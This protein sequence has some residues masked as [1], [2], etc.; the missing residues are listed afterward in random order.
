[1]E[2]SDGMVVIGVRPGYPAAVSGL[3]RGDIILKINR[4]DVTSLEIA[5]E[6]HDA[7]AVAPSSVLVETSRNHRVS[8]YVFKP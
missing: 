3:T 6:Q 7:Y 1:L 5:K 2:K 4:Q 8:L